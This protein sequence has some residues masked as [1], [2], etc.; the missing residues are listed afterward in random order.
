AN[1][2]EANMQGANMRWANIQGANIDF[3]S[4]PLW[5]GSLKMKTDKKQ[6]KQIGY[7]FADTLDDND[8]EEK[9][10]KEILKSYVNT[11]HRVG[12]DVEPIK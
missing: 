3:S 2:Q 7:H 10:I 8:P 5:C 4:W 11:F 6:R 9:A 12:I 1:M